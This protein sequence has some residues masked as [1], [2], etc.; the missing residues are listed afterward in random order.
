MKQVVKA[1][2]FVLNPF[3]A[4]R[5]PRTLFLAW[6]RH[7]RCSTGSAGSS[8]HDSMNG[9]GGLAEILL[10]SLCLLQRLG[11]RFMLA[12]GFC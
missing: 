9:P 1:P 7:Q 10:Q 5:L 4:S 8:L 2:S 11:L 6:P 3:A 12:V